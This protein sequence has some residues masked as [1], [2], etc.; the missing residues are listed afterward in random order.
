WPNNRSIDRT[1]NDR[2][3]V[4]E[5]VQFLSDIAGKD[6]PDYSSALKELDDYA[7]EHNITKL[8]KYCKDRKNGRKTQGKTS[9]TG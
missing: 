7:A 8:I 6:S 4:V 5:E 9:T 2:R 1:L 3:R